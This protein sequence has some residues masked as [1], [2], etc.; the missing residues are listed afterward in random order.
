M[1]KWLDMWN[2]Q[3]SQQK[4]FGLDP[5][6][7]SQISKCQT[8]KDMILGMMEELVELSGRMTQYK[9][10]VL[11]D[12]KMERVNVLDGV[13]DIVKYAIICGQLSGVTSE[14]VYQA[15]VRKS[16]V[17]SD[18]ARGE[19]LELERHTKVVIVDIDGVLADLSEWD[20]K[21]SEHKTPMVN[22]KTVSMIESLKEDFYRDGGFL[23]LEPVNGAKEGLIELRAR[24]WKIVLISARPYWQYKR[25]YSDTV[26]WLG[27][28][29]M[30]YDLLLFNK[31][32]AEAIYEY[33]FPAKPS[34]MVEDKEKHAKEVAGL[35]VEVLLVDWPYNQGLEDTD[36]ITR[37]VNWKQIVDK[38]GYPNK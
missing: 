15:F 22:D 20:K 12:P 32:K 31:D 28:N 35:G 10:H 34:Y 11:K 1:D 9:A 6:S 38:I 29:G 33:I 27:E 5:A 7:M 13:V 24:G 2:I 14:E 36:L 30:V 21:V 16:R 19:R 18:K 25:V 23:R 37:V 8:A 3:E 26:V 4:E 17:V